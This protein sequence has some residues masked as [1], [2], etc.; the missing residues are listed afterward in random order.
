MIR[1][2]LFSVLIAFFSACSGDKKS[3]P[4]QEKKMVATDFQREELISQIN[5]NNEL[6]SHSGN[7]DSV[8]FICHKQ[9]ELCEQFT[10]TRPLDME[11]PKILTYQA[12]AYKV[13]QNPKK[14]VQALNTIIQNFQDYENLPEVM[15]VKAITIDQEI[16]D[17]QAAEKAYLELIQKFP[18]HPF[19]NDAKSLLT[20]LHMSDEELIRSFEA[21]NKKK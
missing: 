18:D 4:V 10:T 14:S 1:V 11:T 16:N 9:A 3:H 15:L 2:L 7:P 17:K 5:E 21:K 20:Q 13:L 19:A 12:K 8:L 6:I